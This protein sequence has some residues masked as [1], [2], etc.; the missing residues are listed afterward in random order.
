[1]KLSINQRKKE[2][3]NFLLVTNGPIFDIIETVKAQLA[4]PAEFVFSLGVQWS[5]PSYLVGVLC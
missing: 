3:R 5:R 1:M 2:P 4:R